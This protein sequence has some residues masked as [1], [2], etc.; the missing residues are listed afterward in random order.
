MILSYSQ[1]N[2]ILEGI[3]NIK[4]Q[5][6]WEKTFKHSTNKDVIAGLEKTLEESF[7]SLQVSPLV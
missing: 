4:G 2:S 5:G 1:L 6:G 3:A 7:T